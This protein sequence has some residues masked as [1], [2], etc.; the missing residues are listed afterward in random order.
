MSKTT[1]DSHLDVERLLDEYVDGTLDDLRAR[2]VRGHLRGCA[3][4]TARVEKTTRL[5]EA[6]SEIP[7]LDPSPALWAKIAGGLDEDEARLARRGRLWWWWQGLGK[8]MTFVGGALAVAAMTVWLVAL[9]GRVP[10]APALEAV[11]LPAS[12]EALYEDAV[13]E[14]ARAQADYQ[15]AVGDLRTIATGERAH[16]KPEVREAFDANLALID[17]AVGRQAELARR[18][19]GDVAVAD[20]LA[21]SYRKEI[22]FLQEA[23]VRGEVP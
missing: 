11:R 18:N 23:V 2:A 4:C 21:E 9:R 3:D 10:L 17:T 6:A 7:A 1:S 15:T 5:L 14:V 20:A 19:P 12:P 13:H 16:W 22:D 8:R